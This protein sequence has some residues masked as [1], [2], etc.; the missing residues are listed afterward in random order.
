M[1]TLRATRRIVEIKSTL[2]DLSFLAISPALML[3]HTS[4]ETFPGFGTTIAVS[5]QQS[6]VGLRP[7]HQLPRPGQPGFP[8]VSPPPREPTDDC[9]QLTP[10]PPASPRLRRCRHNQL[11]RLS[12]RS[13][14]ATPHRVG[15]SPLP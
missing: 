3:G 6:S 14:F 12:R 7:R 4:P 9:S 11:T 2:S 1:T 13:G 10:S 8:A 5:G 15:G